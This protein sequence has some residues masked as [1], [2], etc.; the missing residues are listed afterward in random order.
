MGPDGER[1]APRLARGA[2]AFAVR[3]AGVV[4]SYGWVSTAAEWIGELQLEITPAP[5]EA[6]VWNCF[7][8]EPHRR[9]GHYR[10]VLEGIVSV[11]RAEGLR[12]LWIGSM[13]IPAEKADADAGF[14]R[15]LRFEAAPEGARRRLNVSAVPGVDERLVSDARRR[16]GLRGWTHLGPSRA[17]VH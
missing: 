1:V 16:L 12:R 6:Y 2:R 17:R 15:V 8:L 14:V 9:R 5:G 11:A 4:V 3:E 7:T 10:S 13:A